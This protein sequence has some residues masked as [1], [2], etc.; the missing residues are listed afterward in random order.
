MN[1]SV[2]IIIIVFSLLLLY[3]QI[4]QFYCLLDIINRSIL[5]RFTKETDKKRK[6]EQQ[7][8]YRY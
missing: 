7:M 5:E 4:G 3:Y 6:Q 8:S 2:I 1:R